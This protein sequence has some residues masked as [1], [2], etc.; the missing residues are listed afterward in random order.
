MEKTGDL[1]TN[2]ENLTTLTPKDQ[3][4]EA[5]KTDD[6]G[7]IEEGRPESSDCGCDRMAHKIYRAIVSAVKTGRLVEPFNEKDFRAAC[8]SLGGG[9]Y[10]DFLHRHAI[11]NPSG[12]DELFQRVSPGRF[13]CVRPFK[14][15]L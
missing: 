3:N 11:G 4:T 1:A 8:P 5:A 10:R 14:Y 13:R 12:T 15:G 2:G 7:R 6:P 9:T